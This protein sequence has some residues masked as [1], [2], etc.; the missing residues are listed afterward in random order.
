MT[1][2]RIRKNPISALT[3]LGVFFLLLTNITLAEENFSTL[4]G[5]VISADGEPVAET[6]IVLFHVKIRDVGG[7]ETIYD[8]TLY[9]FLRQ[10]PGPPPNMPAHVRQRMMGKVPNEQDMQTRPPFLRTVTDSEG[11]FTF[12]EIASGLAQIM[13]LHANPPKKEQQPP[14]R[15]HLSYTPPPAI[16][17]INFGKFTFYAHEFSFSPETGGVTFAIQPGAKIENVAVIMMGSNERNQLLIEGKIIFKDGTPLVDTSLNVKVGNLT[18]GETDGDTF[19]RSISTD[20]DGNFRLSVFAPGI[21]SLSIEHLGLS[22]IADMFVL[23]EG[24]PHE[25]VIMALDGNS[26]ELADPPPENGD[27]EMN[28]YRYEPDVPKVW[29]VNPENGHAYMVIRCEDREDAQTIADAEEAH[30]V[31]ITS[32]QEQLWLDAAFEIEGSFGN[33]PYW[34]GLSYATFGSK[35]QWD[36]GEPLEYTNWTLAENDDDFFMRRPPGFPGMDKNFAIMSSEGKWKAIDLEG[37]SRDRVRM[38][39]IEKDGMRAKKLDVEE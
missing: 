37:R 30:L 24:E 12:T 11:R 8:K 27:S 34:I 6:P 22:A 33:E 4:S 26:D 20:T 3:L 14:G 18:L 35:W 38:A 2:L 1:L 32:E 13:V 25:G 10:R 19:S 17:S 23:K 39:V 15:E 9:P 36:T 29:I 28:R 31:T 16:K 21:Y 7:I 5:R